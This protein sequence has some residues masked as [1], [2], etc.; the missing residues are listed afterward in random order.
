VVRLELR[1]VPAAGVRLQA[2]LLEAFLLVLSG[3]WWEK[4]AKQKR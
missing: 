4:L 2:V 1:R 3:S